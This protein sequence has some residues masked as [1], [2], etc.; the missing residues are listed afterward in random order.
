MEKTVSLQ[1]KNY[2]SLDVA[3]FICAVLIISAHFASEKAKFPTIIDYAFSLYV[4]AVP[5]FFVC[6]G[7][8]FFK[9][10]LPMDKADRKVYLIGYQKRIWI[11]YGCW[12]LSC[13]IYLLFL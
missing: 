2:W 8:L 10:W 13:S 6:S 4:I 11:M 1:R 12:N 5:F 7:F 9:K 3:K